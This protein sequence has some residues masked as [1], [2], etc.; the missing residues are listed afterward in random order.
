MNNA[1]ERYQIPN[2]IYKMDGNE[3]KKSTRKERE[4][5]KNG[6]FYEV[7][8]SNKSLLF[9]SSY[10]MMIMASRKKKAEG[11]KTA[12][13]REKTPNGEM[14]GTITTSFLLIQYFPFIYMTVP[15]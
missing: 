11:K 13:N 10:Y 12:Q 5:K 6:S 3:L 4:R 9:S 7:H 2:A 1:M 8:R 14:K 15:F